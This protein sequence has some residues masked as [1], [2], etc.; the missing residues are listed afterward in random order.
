MKTY[1]VGLCY[2]YPYKKTIK[3]KKGV[4]YCIV[5]ADYHK[6]EPEYFETTK[7]FK[8]AWE[9]S[10]NYSRI[11]I[12]SGGVIL[13]ISQTRPTFVDKRIIEIMEK[14]KKMYCPKCEE[15]IDA[16]TPLCKNKE[17]KMVVD[18][19]SVCVYCGEFLQYNGEMFEP[20]EKDFI[21]ELVKNR[22]L[23]KSEAELLIKFQEFIK[24]GS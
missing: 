23:H 8:K 2:G 3:F 9:K 4:F 10:R 22:Q 13:D 12:S 16:C 18:D 19:L 5:Y 20:I 7:A 15:L 6:K 14:L 21:F 24:K 1:I 17:I 11:A